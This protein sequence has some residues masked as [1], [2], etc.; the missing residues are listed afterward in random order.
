MDNY[1]ARKGPRPV[2]ERQIR[3]VGGFGLHR[4]GLSYRIRMVPGV[5]KSAR[6]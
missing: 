6:Q 3:G 2:R 1:Y 4:P 5:R